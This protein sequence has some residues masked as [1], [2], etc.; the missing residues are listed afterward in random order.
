MGLKMNLLLFIQLVL[1]VSSVSFVLGDASIS[2]SLKINIASTV[3]E[4]AKV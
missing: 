3:A 2:I 1:T 4:H